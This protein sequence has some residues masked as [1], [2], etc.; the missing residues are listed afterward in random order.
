MGKKIEDKETEFVFYVIRLSRKVYDT[1]DPNKL[2][3]EAVKY[4]GKPSN[5]DYPWRAKF[6]RTLDKAEEIAK[7]HRHIGYK[8][9][10]LKFRAELDT[11]LGE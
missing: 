1:N 7:L 11:E 8:T 5:V 9:G 3:Y 6:F 4:Y 10:I 2:V